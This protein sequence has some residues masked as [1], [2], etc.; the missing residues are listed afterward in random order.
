[1]SDSSQ[2]HSRLSNAELADFL[3]GLPSVS[4]PII[5]SWFRSGGT[6]EW[7]ADDSP[8]TLADKSTELALRDALI[9]QFPDD[10]ILGEEHAPHHGNSGYAWVV[11]PIDGTRAFICGRPVFGTLVGLVRDD[12]PVAGLIDMPMLD[13]TYVAVGDVATLNGSGITTSTVSKLANARLATTAPEALLADSL[14]A[15]NR[16]S[17]VAA[18]NSYGG[19]CHNY[20]L[21]AAGHLDLVLED[22]LATHD[23][24]GVVQL[25]RAAGGVVTD[26][27]GAPVSMRET[28]SLLAASTPALHAEALAIVKG[29]G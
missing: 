18:T 17:A 20:A 2:I 23:I 14:D 21:L 7:K 1:V 10:D 22:G 28:T 13:E 27:T 29:V 19:D 9:A 4:R 25:I 5:S 3:R 24:M 26:K 8:V 11:D 15:F 12:V 16:L 6:I